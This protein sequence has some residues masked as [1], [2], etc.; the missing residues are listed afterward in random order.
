VRI[1]RMRSLRC[2]RG[3]GDGERKNGGK[4]FHRVLPAIEGA[5]G[6]GCGRFGQMP[7]D[8]SQESAIPA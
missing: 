2:E 7:N 6:T 4:R 1:E 5:N 3:R 8:G